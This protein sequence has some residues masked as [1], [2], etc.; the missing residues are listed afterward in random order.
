MVH[1]DT[2]DPKI[3]NN[4]YPTNC[5]RCNKN[6]KVQVS[7]PVIRRAPPKH[8]HPPRDRKRLAPPPPPPPPPPP[9]KPP[10]RHG[11]RREVTPEDEDFERPKKTREFSTVLHKPEKRLTIAMILLIIVFV[12][13]LIN[14]VNS[15]AHGSIK[16]ISDDVDESATMDVYGRV[17][18]F[19]TGRPI[20]DVKITILETNQATQTDNSGQYY[21][22]NIEVGDHRIKAEL[23]GYTT[24][25][26]KVTM[27]PEL[28]GSVNFE[29]E[30]G[31]GAKTIDESVV[32]IQREKNE[33]NTFAV[34]VIIFACLG[35]FAAILI[36]QRT[37]FY[38]CSICAFLSI[39]SFGIGIGM[40]L[41]VIALVLILMSKAG[42]KKTDDSEE[43]EVY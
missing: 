42:F 38:I 39:L 18:D 40:L 1:F 32:S 5:P 30:V 9:D 28:L 27:D 26:K 34:M 21:F 10:H 17:I 43:L 35:L 4:L 23:S 19:N 2:T 31:A 15:L 33:I 12:L 3:A 36:W 25:T 14:G 37:F 13:G 11:P 16:H 41:G 24:I 8:M 22:S 6:I 29:L 20:Q 7:A